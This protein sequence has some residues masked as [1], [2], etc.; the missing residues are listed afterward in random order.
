MCFEFESLIKSKE[1]HLYNKDSTFWQSNSKNTL[2]FFFFSRKREWL[3]KL[4]KQGQGI[5]LKAVTV[6]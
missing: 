5:V 2:T 6:K 1:A 3:V 4:T